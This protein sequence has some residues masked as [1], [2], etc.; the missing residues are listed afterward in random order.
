MAFNP[1]VQPYIVD[2]VTVYL[3]KAMEGT[4]TPVIVSASHNLDIQIL[5]P[6]GLTGGWQVLILHVDR[7]ILFHG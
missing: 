7:G 4:R 6:A 3:P 1:P 5:W 2:L